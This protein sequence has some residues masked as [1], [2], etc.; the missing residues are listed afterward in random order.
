M[1]L[2]R[3]PE[4]NGLDRTEADRSGMTRLTAVNRQAC[5]AS[6]R[7]FA[8]VLI[9]YIGWSNQTWVNAFPMKP[10]PVGGEHDGGIIRSC[11]RDDPQFVEDY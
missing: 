1:T 9:R 6:S 2:G 10:L 5:T 8:S 3:A 4:W 11:D 7:S